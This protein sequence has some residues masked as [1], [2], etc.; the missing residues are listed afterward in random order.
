MIAEIIIKKLTSHLN[1]EEEILFKKWLS[2][3]DENFLTYQR[4]KKL[5]KENLPLPDISNIDSSASWRHIMNIQKKRKPKAPILNIGLLKYAAIFIGI[6]GCFLFYL[7]SNEDQINQI[8]LDPNAIILELD[9]G[10]TQI[11]S[12]EGTSAIVDLDGN[13]LGRKVDGL[14][15]YSQNEIDANQ[16]EVVRYN[17]IRVPNGKTFKIVLSDGTA[18]NLNAG[19]SLKYPVK[20]ID[21][22]HRQVTLTGEAFFD[23]QKNEKSPFIVTTGTMDVRVLGTK[24][25]LT[26]Y[27]EDLHQST[28]LVEGSVRLYETGSKYDNDN[29]TLLSPGFKADWDNSDKKMIINKVNTDIYTG[30]IEGKLVMKKMNFSNIIQRLQRHYDVSIT[31]EYKELNDRIFTATFEKESIEEVLETFKIETPF[32]YQISG[33]NI[34]IIK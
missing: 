18:V 20:F 32:D 17:T 9:N 16:F 24:F 28:V 25:N 29:S 31:N 5:Q 19:S 7:Y 21:G 11:L 2:K 13:L 6:I 34:K 23:V 14:M 1:K 26:S 33:P 4:L 12:Q 8:Q 27:P 22:Q 15:D 10:E 30:W 3:N